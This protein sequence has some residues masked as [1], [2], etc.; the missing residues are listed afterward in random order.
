M[1]PDDKTPDERLR[2]LEARVE[3]MQA[4]LRLIESHAK[5]IAICTLLIAFASIKDLGASWEQIRSIFS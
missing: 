4:T 5:W 3:G 1:H 2:L